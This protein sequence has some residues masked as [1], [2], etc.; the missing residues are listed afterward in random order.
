MMFHHSDRIVT[1][2]WGDS[3]YY[4]KITNLKLQDDSQSLK[5]TLHILKVFTFKIR[6]Y[7]AILNHNK[8]RQKPIKLK[9]IFYQNHFLKGR[10]KADEEW[11]HEEDCRDV[12]RMWKKLMEGK[13]YD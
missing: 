3:S 1:K 12:G 8:T 11:E 13:E 6:N 9:M 4:L 2:I 5:P 7:S 10:K